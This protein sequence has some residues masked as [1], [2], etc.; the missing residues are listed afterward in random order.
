ME[1]M[2]KNAAVRDLEP[3]PA[4][5]FPSPSLDEKPEPTEKAPLADLWLLW[6]QR[7]FLY[8]VALWALLASTVIAFLI[9]RKYDSTV[10]IMPPDSQGDAGMMLAALAGK[11]GAGTGAAAGGL[12]S[13]AGS[14]LGMKS[15]GALFVDLLRSRTVQDHIIDRFSLQKVYWERY[16]QDA[17]EVLDGR[18]DIKEDRKSGV[19]T[20]TV[21]DRDPQRARDMARTYVDELDQLVAQV[22]TSSARRERIFIEQRL[23]TVKGDLQNAEHEFSNF[24]SKNATLD[25]KEQTKAMVE[26][27][28]I[29]QG[30]LIAAQSEIQSLEQIYT[31]NNVRVRAARAR[32]DE[33]KRQLQKV[34]GTD[35]SLAPDAPQE[36]GDIYPSI[37]KLPLLGVQWVDLYRTMKI[38]ETVYELLNSQY[39][40]ARIQEAKEIPTV[41]VVDPANVP[42]KKSFPPIWLVIAGLTSLSMAGAMAWV[43]GT[44]RW[45]QVDS[46]DPG[47]RL[48]LS[49]WQDLSDH[50]TTLGDRPGL[51]RMRDRW[52]NLRNRHDH[53]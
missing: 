53:S 7:R 45:N 30:Q 21:R 10:R 27:A 1:S 44:T 49:V 26:S 48:A 14:V 6:E 16:K 41:R 17:R 37:R 9:P 5:E 15:S 13:L 20:M 8:R 38:Q 33:L 50:L 11:A 28:A 4:V 42:E 23:V 52:R 47:K 19:I 25:I 39:E 40:M 32:I 29:M 24:A 2:R 18:T 12:A 31:P 51:A 35:E 34:G 3:V 43:V 22:S 36:K 46:E